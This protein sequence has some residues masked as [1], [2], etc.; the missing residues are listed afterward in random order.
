MTAL[1]PGSATYWLDISC[2][3][4]SFPHC[5]VV[6]IIPVTLVTSIVC[7]WELVQMW[8]FLHNALKSVVTEAAVIC[9]QLV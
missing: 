2:L 1:N 7:I 6:T 8:R 4:L 3:S 5:K 9:G